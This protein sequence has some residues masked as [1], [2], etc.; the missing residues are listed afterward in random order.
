MVLGT[1]WLEVTDLIVGVCCLSLSQL[2]VLI[3]V[4]LGGAYYTVC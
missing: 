2:Q 4:F 3:D 1:G